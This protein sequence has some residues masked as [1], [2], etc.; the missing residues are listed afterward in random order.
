[1][2]EHSRSPWRTAAVAVTA[3]ALAATATL[4]VSPSTAATRP[5]DLNAGPQ[6]LTQKDRDGGVAQRLAERASAGRQAYLLTLDT[7]S[8]S[9]AFDRAGGKGTAAQ[10][11][12]RDQLSRVQA[13][14]E[15]VIDQLPS[16]SDVL[17]RT[18]AA[19]AAVAVTSDATQASLEALSGVQSVHPI[20]AKTP[21][22]ASAV[23]LHGAPAAWTANSQT[24]AGTTIAIID[25][26]LDYTHANFGGTGKVSDYDAEFAKSDTA[27]N[28]SSFFPTAK[29]VGGWDFVGN[30]YDANVAARSI[31]KPD[32]N[33]L[34]CG[35][36]GSHVGGSAAGLGENADGSTYTGAYNASTPFGTMKI[37]PGMA[38]A[39]KLVAL[40]VFGC[41]GSTNVVSAAIEKAVDPN[42]DGVPNDHVDVVNMSLGS[43]YGSPNDGD[44]VMADAA[45]RAGVVMAISAG[46]SGDVQDVSGSPGSS[47]RAITVANTV[48]AESVLDGLEVTVGSDAQRHGISRSVAYDWKTKPD[49][50]GDVVALT[51]ANETACAPL[52]TADATK[53][54]GKVAL[55][56]WT[57]GAGLECGSVARGGNLAAAGAKGFIFHNSGET[58]EAGITGSAVIPGVLVVKSGGDAIRAALAAATPVT[59]TGTSYGTVKQNFPADVDTV[60]S[61]SS[62][63]GHAAGALKP[64]VAAVGTSVYSTGV[65]TGTRGEDLSGTSMA[66]PMVAGLAALVKGLRPTWTPEMIKADIMNTAGQ[67]LFLGKNRT[68][69]KYA[70]NRV[71]AGRIKADAALS[72]Q[73]LAY[74][75]DD[76]GAVSVSFGAIEVTGPVSMSKT[77]KVQNTGTTAA[78]YATSYASATSVPGASWSVSPASVTVP[79]GGSADVTVTFS[80]SGRN[81]LTKTADLTTGYL[82]NAGELPREVL[83]A[84]SGRVVLTPQSGVALRVPV[85][86]A[87]RP[88]STM[89]Q[90]AELTMPVGD[91]SAQLALTGD[92]VANGA[93]DGDASNDIFSVAAGFELAAADGLEPM[94]SET[95]D[96]GCLNLPEERFADIAH[97]G[98]TSDYPVQG[99]QAASQAYF[100]VNAHGPWSTPAS[101]IEYDLYIDTNGDK[102]PELV[103][104]NTRLLDEDVFVVTLVDLTKTPAVV[105]DTEL[106][107]NRFGDVD[108]AAFDS[109][110]MIMP[111]WLDKLKAFGVNPSNPRINYGFISYTNLS[112][113]YVDAVGLDPSTGRVSLTADVFNPGI[114]VTDANGAGPLV[115]DKSGSSLTVTRNAASYA[116][117]GGKGLMMVHLH[118]KVGAKAQVVTL[119][120]PT[121]PPTTTPTTTPPTTTPTPAPGMVETDTSVRIKPKKPS[122]R[123]NFK[124][125]VK[126]EADGATPTGRIVLRIDGKRMGRA[127]LEDGRAVFRIE[128]DY[129]VGKHVAQAKYK[130]SDTADTSKDRIRFRV[131]R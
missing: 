119:K 13:A 53:V 100:A 91:S 71:G 19:L 107:N 113:D 122:Y 17:Y 87:P 8:T 77:V 97:I 106:L 5:G 7:S 129:F 92:D 66:A 44:A 116:A 79:A 68:G 24:G 43:G 93:L 1:L 34:D 130:G 72:N 124:V 36:H 39:A 12:A 80:V 58:F 26:G 83:S 15:R 121:T 118:N 128:R 16:G 117:D 105:I 51:G 78:T 67:D 63:G 42:G 64:D 28:T 126:V 32:P 131:V 55:V 57:Q 86:A 46:N 50:T 59:V 61:S 73:V 114:S 14:Q 22:N 60:N 75:T 27:T 84:S 115:L 35:G 18:Q 112:G 54:A 81:A 96:A 70:P 31:P 99:S 21:S 98:V 62:R 89:T 125:V 85:Y 9:Q 120:D 3:T 4:G 30:A 2:S 111:V 47:V 110:T 88:A 38:P 101:K 76:P 20:A 127:K 33:P 45:S 102:N 109:D 49:L 52:S 48:D 95:L 69:A 56:R 29:V 6:S 11:A 90:A 65:G 104:Y 25:T 108:T 23:Q 123:E 37:G 82:D 94:C 41:E 74:V 40:K 10:S 103:A